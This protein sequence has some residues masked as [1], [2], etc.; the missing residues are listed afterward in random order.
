[1][2][3]GVFVT[4]QQRDIIVT[5]DGATLLGAIADTDR[6]F[7]T[8][9]TPA[10]SVA[11]LFALLTSQQ[12]RTEEL[13]MFEIVYFGVLFFPAGVLIGLLG[14]S[15]RHRMVIG[16]VYLVM[17]SMLLELTLVVVSGRTFVSDQCTAVRP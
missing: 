17:A 6:V 15:R 12:V 4:D 10:A 14:S 8:E 16:V 3:R 9:F 13:P 2:V 11:G 5:Y 1:M 7:R